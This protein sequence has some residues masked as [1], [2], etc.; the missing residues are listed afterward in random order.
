MMDG[1]TTKFFNPPPGAAVFDLVQW[2]RQ[3]KNGVGAPSAAWA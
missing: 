1:I 3:V 2:L